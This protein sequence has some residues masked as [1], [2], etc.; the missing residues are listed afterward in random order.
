MEKHLLHG[1]EVGGGEPLQYIYIFHL[2][3]FHKIDTE[4]C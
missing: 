3:V 1:N 4:A 2:I